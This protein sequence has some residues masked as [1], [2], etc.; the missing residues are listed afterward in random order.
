V[1]RSERGCGLNV[2]VPHADA[3]GGNLI[4]AAKPLVLLGW[5]APAALAA[6]C[7]LERCLREIAAAAGMVDTDLRTL[8]NMAVSA[9]DDKWLPRTFPQRAQSLNRKLSRVAHG[10][11]IGLYESVL[12]VER[13]EEYVGDLQAI[14][15]KGVCHA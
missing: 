3:V 7:A 4:E 13:V 15:G 11:P 2:T 1:D 5:S 14:V 8:G 9:E 12:L 6:R 10:A